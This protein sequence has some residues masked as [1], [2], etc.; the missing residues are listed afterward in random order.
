MRYAYYMEP[1]QIYHSNFFNYQLLYNIFIKKGQQLDFYTPINYKIDNQIKVNQ[2]DTKYNVKFIIGFPKPTDYDVLLLETQYYKEWCDLSKDMRHPLT[3]KFKAYNKIIIVLNASM[4]FETRMINIDNIFYG[5]KSSKT[6]KIDNV[7]KYKITYFF[8]PPVTYLNNP[9]PGQ[10]SQ[11]QFYQKYNIDP[12]LKLI[13]F[14]P[15]KLNKWRKKY[16]EIEYSPDLFSN[17]L[18][19]ENYFQNCKQIHWFRDNS[20]TIIDTFRQ[21]GYQLIGKMHIRDF[22]KFNQ[23]DKSGRCLMKNHITYIDQYDTYELFK[24]SSYALTFGS[25]ISYQM[26]LY[27]LPVIDIGTGFYFPGWAYPESND[28][29]YMNLI[30]EYNNGKDLIYGNII[31]FDELQNDTMNHLINLLSNINE[32]KYRIDNPIYGNTYGKTLDD[33]YKNIAKISNIHR[34]KNIRARR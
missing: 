18:T 29:Q 8:L 4:L 26:Y 17:K 20:E 31:N 19:N 11:E 32:F 23:D 7:K 2:I 24:Y 15:G 12:K 1:Y 3:N 34:L 13:A 16:K 5:V 27:D 14:L 10:L 21:L 28:Y 9:K 6:L 30:K 25:T 22:D 33:V